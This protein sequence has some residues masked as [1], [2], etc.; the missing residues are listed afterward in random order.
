MSSG[1]VAT[2]GGLNRVVR[3]HLTALEG[4]PEPV[5]EAIPFTKDASA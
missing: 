4:Q 1:H 3:A 5:A 2:I